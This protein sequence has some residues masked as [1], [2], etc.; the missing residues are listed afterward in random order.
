MPNREDLPM[1]GGQINAKTILEL[2]RNL[3]RTARYRAQLMRD[4]VDIFKALTED[5]TIEGMEDTIMAAMAIIG[6]SLEQEARELLNDVTALAE[7]AARE[8]VVHAHA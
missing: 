5:Q 4:L 8:Q 2:V 1:E 7:A 3:D 6:G